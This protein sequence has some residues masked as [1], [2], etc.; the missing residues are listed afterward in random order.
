[1]SAYNFIAGKGSYKLK[2]LRIGTTV[3]FNPNE[4]ISIDLSEGLWSIYFSDES[5]IITD[6]H[7]T[8]EL[9]EIKNG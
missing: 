2:S 8:L 1:M 6:N 9:V 3:I 7:V 4:I 5:I